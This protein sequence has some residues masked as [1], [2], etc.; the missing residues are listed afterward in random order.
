MSWWV[1]LLN[2]IKCL[3]RIST[4]WIIN[5][6]YKC[7]ATWQSWQQQKRFLFLIILECLRKSCIN[8]P[9]GHQPLS[10]QGTFQKTYRCIIDC[11]IALRG[12]LTIGCAALV[13]VTGTHDGAEPPALSLSPPAFFLVGQV[14]MS[15]VQLVP[16]P[17][18][19][20][21][22]PE[23][24]WDCLQVALNTPDVKPQASEAESSLHTST[25]N[26]WQQ[27]SMKS[28]MKSLWRE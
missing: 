12:G 5:E 23:R 13:T 16:F 10:L 6:S 21:R 7:K 19:L 11:S 3:V 14:K 15:G 26:T 4:E 22:K 28:H 20:M 2:L 17:V 9:V 18:Q 24:C 8:G 27:T 1:Y 25:F